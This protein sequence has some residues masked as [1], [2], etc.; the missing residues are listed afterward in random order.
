M[1]N[2]LSY[3]LVFYVVLCSSVFTLFTTLIQLYYDYRKDIRLVKDN[4]EVIQHSY[5]DSLALSLYSVNLSQI[6]SQLSGILNLENIEFV[7]VTEYEGKTIAAGEEPVS[8][9]L[10]KQFPVIYNSP[11]GKTFDLG[12]LKVIASFQN[13]RQRMVEKF[14]FALGT[15][16]IKTSIVSI[17]FIIIVQF[18]VTRHLQRMARFVK[19]ASP[20]KRDEILSLQGRKKASFGQDELDQLVSAIN[21]M[22]ERNREFIERRQEAEAQI[23]VHEAQFRA[24]AENSNDTIIRMIQN[25]LITYT[26]TNIQKVTGIHRDRFIGKRFEDMEFPDNLCKI[27]KRA[28]DLTFKSARSQRIEF[29]LPNGLWMDCLLYPE[30]DDAGNIA[31]V[32]ASARDISERKQT[33]QMIQE[34]NKRLLTVLDNIPADVYVSDLVTHEVL[35]M[36][37]TMVDSFKND[38]TGQTCWKVFRKG[39]G[40]CAHCT[41]DLLLDTDGFP[42]GVLTWEVKN[43]VNQKEYL[44]YDVAI[45]WID[46]RY[47]HLQ[48]A[49]DISARKRAEEQLQKAH[50]E[51]EEQVEIRTAEYKGAKDEAEKANQIKSEFLANISHELRNPMHQ[52]L[53]YSKYGIDK[54]NRPKA[55]LLH[56]FNQSRKAAERLMV[57][58]NDLLDLSKMESGRMDYILETHNLYQIANEAVSELKP[59]IE[60]K[61]L[62]L[63]I[64]D[65]KISTK[66]TCD[67]YKLGQV[68]RNLL[69]NAIKFTPEKKHIEINFERNL[70]EGNSQS[71][72]SLQV[73]VCDQGVGIPDSELT[74][75]FD[76]FSQSSKT[77]T[78]AGGTGLGLPICQEIIKAHGGRIWAENNTF[79]GT[80]ISFDLPLEHTP[81]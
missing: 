28:V 70:I 25:R 51:L 73:S 16:T 34:S 65:P 32:I 75:V 69:S 22:Q 59:S 68:M 37:T 31:S 27:W 80:T 47:V 62:A 60:E 29:L 35:Y 63:N 8:Q 4:L 19:M 48:I 64:I 18:I 42:S 57:L 3:K 15:N 36:N 6:K 72:P 38:Y 14:L 54:I 81:V 20:F 30:T 50:D 78:G 41:G 33:E 71:M 76:K 52:I 5:L 11:S 56:Y 55:K 45:K 12:S 1:K 40:P 7:A 44:N 17:L 49:T 2:R 79:G 39:T 74:T 53:S 67:Y 24:L 46:D 13:I 10:V 21:K 43:P 61:N 58:L 66:I 26:N 77:K 23:R 9:D